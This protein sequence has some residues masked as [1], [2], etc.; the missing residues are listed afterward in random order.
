MVSALRVGGR[1]L[2]DLASRG[3]R[4]APRAPWPVTVY[5]LDVAPTDDPGVLAI[6]VEVL[7]RHVR[8]HA[9]LRPRA[10]ARRGASCCELRR[11]AVGPFRIEEARAPRHGPSCSRRSSHL[12]ALPTV[13][14]DDVPVPLIANGRVLRSAGRVIGPWAFVDGSR[15]VCSRCTRISAPNGRSRRSSWSGWTRA[16]S[17][18]GRGGRPSRGSGTRRSSARSRASGAGGRRA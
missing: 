18:A 9:R 17:D 8:A 13:V 2:H 16:I 6:D 5:A 12:R 10:P 1:R 11:T 14:V 15:G 3:S 4:S 7:G